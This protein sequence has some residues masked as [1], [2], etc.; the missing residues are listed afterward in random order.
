MDNKE[1]LE[2]WKRKLA[3]LE[4]KVKKLDNNKNILIWLYNEVRTG[5]NIKLE[6]AL[7]DL[8]LKE[9]IPY[10]ND[11]IEFCKGNIL[12]LKNRIEALKTE[13][14]QQ[15]IED[16]LLS[17]QLEDLEKEAK[18]I[19]YRGKT[20]EGKVWERAPEKAPEARIPSPEEIEEDAAKVKSESEEAEKIRAQV[21]ELFADRK[22]LKEPLRLKKIL[23]IIKK[24]LVKAV[25]KIKKFNNKKLGRDPL[26]KLRETQEIIKIPFTNI[27]EKI[28]NLERQK[29]IRYA[30]PAIMLVLI[31][32]ILLVSK[33]EITGYAVLT[34]KNTYDDNLNLVINESG[35]YTW[36]ADNEGAIESI[37]ASGRIKGNGTVKIYIEKDGERYLVYGNK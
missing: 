18:E 15:E 8:D 10:I 33:P 22:D 2:T 7:K 26:L 19:P 25:E 24:P 5:R 36:I 21:K 12:R 16:K 4:D 35:N 27:S 29:L 30:L 11:K 37:K 31:V 3:E 34:E 14:S 1:L 13:I 6:I 9:E 32:S 20:G 17:Q 23:D 28:S